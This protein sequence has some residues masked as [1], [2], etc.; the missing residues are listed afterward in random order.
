MATRE[1]YTARMDLEL[2]D[3]QIRAETG[4]LRTRR[5]QAQLR[6]TRVLE[7]QARI[8]QELNRLIFTLQS[9]FGV[10]FGQQT[11]GAGPPPAPG[12]R[13]TFIQKTSQTALRRRIKELRAKLNEAPG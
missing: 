8:Q 10:T 1:V 3:R 13:V 12:G 5:E 4:V 7:Q 11:L 6:L 2:L 9:G